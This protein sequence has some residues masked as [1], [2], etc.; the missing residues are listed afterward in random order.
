MEEEKALGRRTVMTPEVIE[1]LE[2]A[3]MRSL[4]DLDACFYAGIG[5][6]ALYDYQKE[7]PEFTERKHALRN[8]PSVKARANIV[9]EIDKGDTEASMW[10]LERKEKQEFSTRNEL[11]G[12][13]GEP[14]KPVETI[15]LERVS[16]KDAEPTG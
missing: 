15:V 16:A 8:L 3:F 11:T 10:W 1:K 9:T 2:Q 6:T 12:A 7:H 14:L 13:D 5:K 4:S